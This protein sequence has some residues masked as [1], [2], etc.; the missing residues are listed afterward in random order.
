[1]GVSEKDVFRF[2]AQMAYLNPRLENAS[3]ILAQTS[4]PLTKLSW[5]MKILQADFNALWAKM[6]TDM[7]PALTAVAHGLD[8]ILKVAAKYGFGALSGAAEGASKVLFGSMLTMAG[9]LGIKLYGASTD[10]ALPGP[11]AWMKQLPTSAF[12]KM[13]LITMGGSNN[14]A[15][16]TARN[17]REMVAMLKELARRAGINKNQN[18]NWGFGP[19]TSQP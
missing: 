8:E 6:V 12:E 11:Q 2:G 4:M 7:A 19:N 15:K 17:T 3:K 10:K 5:E 16:E 13:G 1:M 9:R 14:Y 18:S